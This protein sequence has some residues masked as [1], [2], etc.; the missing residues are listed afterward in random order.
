MWRVNRAEIS[1]Q[2]NFLTAENI[3]GMELTERERYY[4]AILE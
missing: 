2:R 3:I 1:V 4:D